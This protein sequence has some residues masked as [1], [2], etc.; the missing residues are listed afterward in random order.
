MSD[1]VHTSRWLTSVIALLAALAAALVFVPP[2]A[3]AGPVDQG[4][5]AAG[6]GNVT[7]VSDGSSSA[8]TMTYALDPAGLSTTRSW[9]FTTS[10]TA[11]SAIGPIKVPWTWEGLHAWYQVT[12]SLRMVVNGVEVGAPLVNAGPADCC[13]TPSNGFLYGGVSTFDVT[14]GDTY[15]FRLSG[16]NSDFN[17]FLRGTFT[18][19]TRPYVDKLIGTDNRDWRGA[20]P[21]VPGVTGTLDETGEARWFRFPVVPGQQVQVDLTDLPGDYDV[22]LYG[23]IQAAFDALL[24]SSDVT[25]LAASSAAGAPGS[26][27]QIPEYPV[28]VTTVPTSAAQLPSTTFAPRIYAPRIYAPRIYAPRI[29]A[30]RIYA[31]RIY[32]PRIYAPDSYIPDLAA[33][34]AFRDAF[35]AAQ[36]QTLLAVSAN[37]GTEVERVSATTGNTD[38]YFYVRVQGHTDQAFNATSPF[39]LNRTISG[40][41]ACQGLTDYSTSPTLGATRGDASTVIVTDT[42]QLGLTTGSDPYNAYLASLGQLSAATDGVVVDVS[43]SARVRDLQ[44]QVDGHPRCPYATNLVARAVKDIVDSYRN[45]AST[46]VV[47]AGGDDVIPFFRYP[48]VSGLGQES[49]FEPPLNGNTPPGASL[50]EDQVLSQDAYGSEIEVT[51]GGATVP[52]PDLAVGRLVKTPD[53]ITSVIDHYLGL[54]DG[55]LPAPTRSL[56][57]GYDFLQDAADGV[58]AEFVAAL[59]G[60]THDTLI[61]QSGVAPADSWKAAELEAKLLGPSRPDLVFLAGHFSANDTLAADFETTLEADVLAPDYQGGVNKDKL[62]NT[63]VLSPGC[64]SGYNIVDTA[65]TATTNTF[66]WTQRMAQQKAV[67]IGGTG[68]QYGDTDFLEY[69]ERLYLDVARRLH[70]GPATGNRPPVAVGKALTLAKQDYLGSLSTLTGIDQKAVLQATLYGLPMTGFDAPGRTPLGASASGVTPVEVTAGPGQTLGLGTTDLA[71]PTPTNDDTKTVPGETGGTRTLS[72]RDGRDGV[73]VQP[74]APALPKQV[75]D[76]TV[77]GQVL[78]GVGFRGGAYT[79]TPGLLPLTGAPA[80]EGSTANSTFLYDAFFP[81]RLVTPNY[82]GALGASGR[83]SLVLTPAQ[84]RSDGVG[85][86]TNTERAYSDLD[87]RLFY[88]GAGST[89]YGANRPAL[90]A[91]PST[92]NVSGTLSNGIVTFST[93]VTGDPSAGVQEVWVT[94][95]G[96]PNGAGGGAWTSLDLRQD[97]SDSTLWRG[98]MPL[99]SGQSAGNLRF[100]VQAANGIGAVGLDT[101]EGDGYRVTDLAAA[102]PTYTVSSPSVTEGNSGTRNLVFTITLSHAASVDLAFAPS[103]SGGTAVAG[104][105]YISPVFGNGVVVPAGELSVDVTVTVLGDT[106][107]EPDETVRLA[108]SPSAGSPLPAGTVTGV[109]TIISDDLYSFGGFRSPIDPLPVVNRVKS[110]Q[111]IP[112][113]FSLGGYRGLGIFA[114]GSPSTRQVACGTQAVIDQVGSATSSKSGLSYDPSRDSYHYVWKTSSAWKNTCRVLTLSFIDGSSHSA[115]FRFK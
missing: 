12:A 46:Y 61:E 22:A 52:L 79:D 95:T 99:P 39:T 83:T 5:S 7:T 42:N 80:I 74:G 49:Q 90:A 6:P 107:V 33:D 73:T 20:K 96:G 110:G 24:T 32:A 63:L 16:S 103:I 88:S 2:P 57:T 100:V 93:R 51:I 102:L 92:S 82:F 35:S 4:W 9:D 62:M 8:A 53:E 108:V 13:T 68:Y 112:V 25:Q 104:V 113:K 101:A 69:S 60:G 59:P 65:G 87:V 81:Q 21:L 78:R 66:D 77:P 70:E 111:A 54:V 76:V 40:N 109:G 44:L 38:G 97:P 27:T 71:V 37:T 55:T 98:T 67:L 75:E 58:N 31:P 30:P 84:Y 18:L 11:A 23:D 26:Q 43:G 17:N 34:P 48:D 3:V 105:D 89:S 114:P 15:G 86:F 45:G 14:P 91:P 115:S 1:T 85:A 64:H 72:W 47:I 10:A 28:T 29:Y 56:V 106:T 50:T 36:N 19:S 94:W 41:T